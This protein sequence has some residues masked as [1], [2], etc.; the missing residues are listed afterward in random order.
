[1][2]SVITVLVLVFNNYFLKVNIIFTLVV[3]FSLQLGY[4]YTCS[5]SY[6]Q[7]WVNKKSIIPV[8]IELI[9]VLIGTIVSKYFDLA[10]TYGIKIVGH[11]SV[12]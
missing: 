4:N 6:L 9:V 5:F 3:I 12:G 1:M 10:N 11:I 2:I 8:P 7:P